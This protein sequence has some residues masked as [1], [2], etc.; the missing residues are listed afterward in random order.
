MVN[1]FVLTLCIIIT[2]INAVSLYN[3]KH[4]FSKAKEF[5]R[6]IESN[7]TTLKNK[8][9]QLSS[10]IKESQQKRKEYERTII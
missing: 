1:I 5:N 10:N 6:L 8:F 3:K 4:V 2:T 7:Y 9:N